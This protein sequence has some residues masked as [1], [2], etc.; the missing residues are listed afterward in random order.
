MFGLDGETVLKKV[1]NNNWSIPAS[2]QEYDLL[3]Q[4]F[5]PKWTPIN[6]ISKWIE[7]LQ[8]DLIPFEQLDPNPNPNSGPAECSALRPRRQINRS[9]A[10]EFPTEDRR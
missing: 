4:Q 6:F 2:D 10:P 7:G 5:V 8:D 1:D 3:T 9:P